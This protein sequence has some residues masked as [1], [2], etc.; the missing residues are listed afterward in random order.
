[1]S[2]LTKVLYLADFTS[3]DRDYP[4]VDVI[5][6]LVDI[7]LDKALK[8]AISYTVKDLAEKGCAIHIDTV[9]AYNEIMLKEIK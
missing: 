6:N 8:Y 9:N 2:L 4:D 5:R 1:M 3:K 7:S